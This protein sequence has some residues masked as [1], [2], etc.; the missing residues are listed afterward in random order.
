MKCQNCGSEVPEGSVFCETCG[1]QLAYQG[2]CTNCGA[3]L[4][5][6][7]SF[8]PNCGTPIKEE[9]PQQDK[10][11]AGGPVVKK[12][13]ANQV[14]PKPIQ[15]EAVIP[16]EPVPLPAQPEKQNPP[17]AQE[18]PA[19]TPKARSK[20]PLI[21]GVLGVIVIVGGVY[22]YMAGSDA[23]ATTVQTSAVTSSSV[24]DETPDTKPLDTT[25]KQLVVKPE[26]A[27]VNAFRQYHSLITSHKLWE[28]YQMYSD[29]LKGQVAYQ[30]WAE[31]YASTLSSLPQDI[32][33]L[34]SDSN[35]VSLSFRLQAK[36]RIDNNDST[37][38]FEGTCSLVKAGNDWKIDEITARKL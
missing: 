23:P 30:G 20:L 12:V 25:E 11:E 26:T 6:D 19:K 16:T 28:A 8:C 32:H 24:V 5:G 35:H 7:A 27:A 10:Q 4:E 38:Y 13:T 21:L 14:E 3:P 36:D 37:Q 2:Y 18:L 33:V 34:Q 22:F 29:T 17:T 1:A 9:E 31:G 15:H